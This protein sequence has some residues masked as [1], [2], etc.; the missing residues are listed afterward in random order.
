MLAALDDCGANDAQLAQFDEWWKQRVDSGN[1]EFI[2]A[3]GVLQMQKDREV[4]PGRLQVY[5]WVNRDGLT[6]SYTHACYQPGPG[7]S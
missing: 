2:Y 5:R 6:G 1:E 7:E 3:R 4:P